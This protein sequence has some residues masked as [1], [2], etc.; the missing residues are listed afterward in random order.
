MKSEFDDKARE[1]DNN[2]T[3]IDRSIVIA[4][5]IEKELPAGSKLKA[6]EY[7]AGT[8]LLSFQLKDKLKEV[9]LM[10][11]SSEMIKVCEEKKEYYKASHFRPIVFDLEH[12]DFNEKFDLIYTQMVM[13]HVVNID[14]IL[15][16][17]E[18]MLNPNGILAI[19]DLYLE[20]GT[21]HGQEVKVHH[22]FDPEKLGK[23][24]ILKGFA[25]AGH[26]KCFTITR[27][28]GIDY[29]IFLLIAKK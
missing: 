26:K 1:W 5:E 22:G 11:N 6:L 9:V 16:K 21:F 10:D 14:Q 13:H 29:P 7:G 24:L 20:D 19:A 2:K 23:S 3:H 12:N 27:P 17:F 15:D 8:G 4:A 28:N 18:K 25:N